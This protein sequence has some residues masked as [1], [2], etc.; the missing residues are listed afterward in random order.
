MD[1]D[2]F[3]I[4]VYVLVDDWWHEQDATA[5]RGPGRPTV[6]SMSE[7]LTLAVVAQWPRWR[8]ERDFWRLARAPLH[9]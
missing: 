5:R 8:S 3:L 1:L 9:A 4:A 2:S 7:V 6:L